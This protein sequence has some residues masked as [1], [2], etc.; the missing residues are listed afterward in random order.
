MKLSGEQLNALTNK[1]YGDESKKCTYSKD[2][3]KAKANPK[4]KALAKKYYQALMSIPENV[5]CYDYHK[6]KRSES[7][8]LNIIAKL[9]VKEPKEICRQSIK[10]K[11]LIASI[12]SETLVQLQSKLNVKL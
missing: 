7:E 8:F 10:D 3:E 5:R 9:Q 1:I 11:I 4:N 12:E 2:I 6:I